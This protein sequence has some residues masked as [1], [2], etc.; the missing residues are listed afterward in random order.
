MKRLLASAG[1]L[2]VAL[3]AGATAQ[4]QRHVNATAGG[5]LRPGIYGRIELRGPTPPPLVWAQPV[6]VS[7][8]PEGA[9]G[10]PLYLYVPP[11]HVRRWAQ[12]CA[13][14]QACEKPVLFV[15]MDG[16]PSRLGAWKQAQRREVADASVL[17][18]FSRFVQP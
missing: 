12:H 2:G 9:S 5:P 13:K 11:G 6:V 4:D 16:S 10:K 1:L 17:Q 15:R 8:P 18:A 3:A 14:W 7:P